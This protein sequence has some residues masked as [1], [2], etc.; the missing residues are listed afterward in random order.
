MDNSPQQPQQPDVVTDFGDVPTEETRH[1]LL[2]RLFAP[3]TNSSRARRLA[4]ALLGP[5]GRVWDRDGLCSVGEQTPEGPNV[6]GTGK[7]FAEAFVDATS[8]LAPQRI[9]ELAGSELRALFTL[10][11]RQRETLMAGG[12]R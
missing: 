1:Q 10:D 11:Q 4:K 7:T 3:V 6:Y 5:S 2:E 9:E 12:R 8:G